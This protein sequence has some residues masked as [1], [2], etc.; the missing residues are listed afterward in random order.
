MSTPQS[1]MTTLLRRIAPKTVC[2]D[3]LTR[4]D[5]EGAPEEKKLYTVY[6]MATGTR[7]GKTDRGE[8]VS[9]KGQ[10][11]AIRAD[12][13]KR[14]VSG[15]VFLQPPFDDMLYAKLLD[16]Q[17]QDSKAGVQ[18]AIQ[19]SIVRP[20]KGKPS[21]TG[22]EFRVVPVIESEES[23]PLALLRTQVLERIALPA[24]APE[25]KTPARPAVGGK[26]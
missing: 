13:Q 22:Y 4:L 7:Q 8:W 10:F 12:N 14:F 23:S 11:E 1:A 18:F 19:V 16:A 21:A 20:T 26:K 15:Q 25:D 3:L 17:S 6:G 2:E 9:F 5:I 24:P